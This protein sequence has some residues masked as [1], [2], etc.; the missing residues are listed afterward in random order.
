MVWQP[1]RQGTTNA[2]LSARSPPINPDLPLLTGPNGTITM[3]WPLAA[4]GGG[5]GSCAARLGGGSV[6]LAEA[7]LVQTEGD[8]AW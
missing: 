7:T 4:T 8:I 5:I 2:A 6:R 1:V 3:T